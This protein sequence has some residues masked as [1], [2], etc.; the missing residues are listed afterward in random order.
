MTWSKVRPWFRFKLDGEQIVSTGDLVQ[1][2]SLV[3]MTQV[4]Q[5]ELYDQ[6]E[7]A[8][9]QPMT[10]DYIDYE[11]DTIVRQFAGEL[12]H[13]NTLSFPHSVT[14][15][16]VGV[17]TNL[18]LSPNADVDLTGMTDGEAIQ[19]VLEGCDIPFDPDDIHDMEYVLGAEVPVK[20]TKDQSGWEIVKEIDLVFGTCTME[21]GDARVV[22]FSYDLVPDAGDSYRSFANGVDSD[23]FTH[24]RDLWDKDQIQN[25]FHVTGATWE[26]TGD[27]DNCRYTPW[28]R[29]SGPNLDLGGSGRRVK[30]EPFHSDIIQ[31]QTLAE[32]VAR[33]LMRWYNRQP[34]R[35]G[36]STKNDIN[37][38]PGRVVTVESEVYG[39]DLPVAKPYVII[40]VDRRG[41]TILLDC[42][43]GLAGAEGTVT[44]GV[45][46][47]C[48][49]AISDVGVPGLFEPPL[50]G[51]PLV[52]LS[53]YTPEPVI[54]E[55]NE[56]FTIGA[57]I[58]E[59]T[60]WEISGRVEL[61]LKTQ[62]LKI[63]ILTEGD[64]W[65]LTLAGPD[66]YTGL[67]LDPQLWEL[68][69]PAQ[70]KHRRG[71]ITMHEPIDYVLQWLWPTSTLNLS[72]TFDGGVSYSTSM[73]IPGSSL[74]G[75][76][77]TIR[78]LTGTPARD[79]EMLCISEP[80]PLVG[81]GGDGICFEP[82]ASDWD[83][84]GFSVAFS[85]GGYEFNDGSEGGTIRLI[86]PAVIS[87]DQLVTWTMHVEYSGPGNGTTDAPSV[88]FGLYEIN[89]D[90]PGA[91]VNIYWLPSGEGYID[92][93]GFDSGFHEEEI[94]D[95][96]I[97]GGYDLEVTW[98]PGT[99]L[100]S[101]DFNDGAYANAVLLDITP[102]VDLQ[103]RAA[104]ASDSAMEMTSTSNVICVGGQ[105][106]LGEVFQGDW[107]TGDN[108]PWGDGGTG[109]WVFD[110]VTG[111][112]TVAAPTFPTVA[113]GSLASLRTGIPAATADWRL[114][115]VGDT[116]IDDP[117]F[118]IQVTD[119][120]GGVA[121]IQAVSVE[122]ASLAGTRTTL[123]QNDD[124]FDEPAGVAFAS[125]F[126]IVIT[127]T[128]D[129]FQAEIEEP[130]GT[131]LY[132]HT[133]GS[134]WTADASGD[135]LE[136]SVVAYTEGIGGSLHVT[137]L[138]LEVL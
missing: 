103:L 91:S 83:D 101:Y 29:A 43:G 10:V 73:S 132:T 3:Q 62:R 89:P 15:T 105:N 104:F 25:K 4:V 115:A 82:A 16:G 48:N 127:K 74:L 108:S 137:Q 2:E 32:W 77:V 138:T 121:Y 114:T 21:I 9:S 22:R 130:V 33:R 129:S 30:T 63:G 90:G 116:N 52:P 1:N 39:I 109:T 126:K 44:F 92:L 86:D 34:D 37:L 118:L 18:R 70:Y 38:C 125:E 61:G 102:G 94:T 95:A 45:E 5:V 40:G 78:E 111:E 53:P 131:N 110:G 120:T 56:A 99:N 14:L 8:K 65:Y 60:S 66:Y 93:I 58:A 136:V 122:F 117:M 85:T 13:V 128:G 24:E 124:D 35:L 71:S 107:A 88:D 69:S 79:G 27:D 50:L 98:N 46:K 100:L 28:A 135:D 75:S 42:V 134:T 47:V 36:I 12:G 26:G 81:G 113:W 17:L 57:E 64:E 41:P 84:Q 133:L 59:G 20:W 54:C 6:P 19:A 67:M 31:D 51:V 87:D 7:L 112:V 72:V 123:F 76:G 49:K 68:N 96:E 106:L 11:A 23:F 55:T 119:N 80:D 97:F